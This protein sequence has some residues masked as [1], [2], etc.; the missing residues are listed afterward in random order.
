MAAPSAMRATLGVLRFALLLVV[1]VVVAGPMLEHPRETVE[2]DWVLVLADRSR[3]MQIADAD[4]SAGRESRELITVYGERGDAR[5]LPPALSRR[6]ADLVARC[7]SD[8]ARGA[9]RSGGRTLRVEVLEE[10]ERA[11]A[12]RLA[13]EEVD[14][15]FPDL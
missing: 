15:L 1:L 3:S 2:Q 8:L 4:A 7:E 12:Q 10:R 9:P 11:E 6:H 5:P 14:S 13:K